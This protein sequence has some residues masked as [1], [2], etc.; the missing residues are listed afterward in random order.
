MYALPLGEI[1]TFCRLPLP[2]F[3]R[4]TTIVYPL[5]L[6]FSFFAQFP[7]PICPAP[8]P[9]SYSTPYSASY[10]APYPVSYST[11]YSASYPAPYSASYPAPYPV[12]YI[13]SLFFPSI[14]HPLFGGL[15][16]VGDCFASSFSGSAIV[17]SF[18]S[19]QWKPFSM[20]QA[21][22]AADVQEAFDAELDLRT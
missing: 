10:P 7:F 6:P 12:S 15:L 16:F 17:F 4:C 18:L 22:V 11:P 9:V 1:T 21:S 20:P 5:S 19:S 14:Q 13:Y 3:F 8:Y 2:D